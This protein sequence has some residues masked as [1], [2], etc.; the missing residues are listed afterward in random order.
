[1]YMDR[2]RMCDRLLF[3]HSQAELKDCNK[4]LDKKRQTVGRQAF[5]ECLAINH[6]NPAAV[7]LSICKMHELVIDV[8]QLKEFLDLKK[9]PYIKS[10][11]DPIYEK[12]A[13]ILD[14]VNAHG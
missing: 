12:A 10:F 5:S 1:M 14:E 9:L 8:A 13:N 3:D 7:A 2:C 11:L 6:S 4:K